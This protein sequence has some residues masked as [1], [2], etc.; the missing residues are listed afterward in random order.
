MY[1]YLAT[2]DAASASH[3]AQILPRAFPIGPLRPDSGT[4]QLLVHD[5][6]PNIGRRHARINILAFFSLHFVA[7]LG[8]TGHVTRE[9]MCGE[10]DSDMRASGE[11]SSPRPCQFAVLAAIPLGS[12]VSKFT[13]RQ[14]LFSRRHAEP[15]SDGPQRLTSDGQ[16]PFFAKKRNKVSL[17]HT[18]PP[19]QDKR[20]SIE[21]RGWG[22]K[23][24]PS[25]AGDRKPRHREQGM[26]DAGK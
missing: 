7:F 19:R 22:Q 26:R 5:L 13:N 6:P 9:S 8:K 1:R 11:D 4:A 21:S 16:S 20:A 17:S 2:V 24:S 14:A 3:A 15:S 12:T 18:P 10:K 23:A 25:R